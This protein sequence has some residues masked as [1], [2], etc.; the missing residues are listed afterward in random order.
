MKAIINGTLV[1]PDRITDGIVLI[2]GDRI[3]A[4][5]NVNIPAGAE[6]IDAT[7]LYVGPGFVDQHSH[8]YQHCGESIPVKVDP[9][10]AAMAHLKHGVTTYI[11]STDYSDTLEE[12]EKVIQ[13][14][15]ET[16][17]SGVDTPIMGIHLEGPYINRLFGSNSLGAMDY[18]DDVCEKLFAMASPY[19]R[20][21]TY[22]PELPTAPRLEEKMRK[23]GITGA[24]GHTNAGP[25]DVERAVAYGARIATHLYDA[26]G[27][28]RSFEDAAKLTQHPQNCTAN[29]LLGIPG[30]YYELICDSAQM[31]TTKYSVCEALRAGGEDYI[32]LISDAFVETAEQKEENEVNFDVT[33]CLSGSRLCLPEA[34]R[35][36][37][38]F[39]GVDMKAAF[40]CAATNSAKA[41]GLFDTVGSIDA[42]KLANVVLVDPS[43]HVKKVFFKGQEVTE[44]RD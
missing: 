2:E 26:S 16:L 22:A 17:N 40:K 20:H 12:H 28:D 31:H 3:V 30:M 35:N 38:K 19:V 33:G 36:F 23:Y 24:I 18:D 13:L 34:I 1:F 21:C 9:Q 8:G 4:S 14:C 44:I 25:A 27:C 7:G 6:I 29:I 39:T 43:F 42:G 5:G 11:P 41:L 32:V 15:V 10:A 37:I